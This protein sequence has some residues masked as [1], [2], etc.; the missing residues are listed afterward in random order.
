MNRTNLLRAVALGIAIC[1]AQSLGSCLALAEDLTAASPDGSLTVTFALDHGVPTYSVARRGEPLIETS[2]L[3]IRLL[4]EPSLDGDFKVAGS[5]QRSVDETW[6]Q[7]WGE[8][9]LVRCQYNEL[10]VE[11]QQQDK[12]ARRMVVVFRVFDDGIGFRYEW[13][14]QPNLKSLHIADELTEFAFAGEPKAWWIPAFQR[15]HYEYLYHRT[16]ISKVTK[17]HTPATFE[18]PNGSFASIHEAALVDYSSMTLAGDGHSM[19]RA[20]LT[21]WSDGVKV[22]ATVPHLSPWRTIQVADT[23][24]GLIES[25]GGVV[26]L[27]SSKLWGT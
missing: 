10:R 9:R 12:G 5:Q 11:L 4:G 25:R 23:P 14:E 2:R 19:L 20:D 3:G 21:P 16:P 26:F 13:P 22:K 17:A 18:L 1:I 8:C 7:P 6:E 27:Y 24:G 15:E